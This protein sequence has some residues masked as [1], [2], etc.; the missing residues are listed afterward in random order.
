MT[1]EFVVYLF[2]EALYTAMLVSA[3]ILVLSLF[4]GLV[5]SVFQ[6]ATSIQEFT[7]TFVPKI[8]AVVI[9]LLLFLPWMINVM[10]T[11]T[12]NLFHQIPGLTR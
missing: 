4:V 5:I 7:L 2:R 11:F 9:V 3:P 10:I 8:V 12:V 1:E 6:A